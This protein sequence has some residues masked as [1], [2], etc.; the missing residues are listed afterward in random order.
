MKGRPPLPTHLKVLRGTLRGDRVNRLEPRPRLGVP[1]P[2]QELSDAVRPIRQRLARI[3]TK[4]RVGSEADGLAVDLVAMAVAECFHLTRRIER[5]GMSYRTRTASG[6]TMYRQR[7]EVPLAA[8]AWRRALAGLVQLGLTPS[9]RTRVAAVPPQNDEL[10]T[11]R[12]RRFGERKWKW[13][14]LL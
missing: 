14:G 9:S 10:N 6:S 1:P 3:L 13:K 7:P 4:L 12:A 2:T 8:D 11:F 5:S